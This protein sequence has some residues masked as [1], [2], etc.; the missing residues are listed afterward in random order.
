MKRMTVLGGT[1]FLGS[2]T[3][4][5]L[6]ALPGVEVRTASRR[7]QLSVDVTR[8]HTFGALEGT[9]LLIDLSNA[10]AQAPDELI[11]WC[12]ARGVAVLEATSDASCIERLHRRF[13]GTSGRLVLGGGIFTGMSNLLARDVASRVS[14]LRAVTLGIASSPFSGAGAGTIDL[15]LS[16]LGA[17]VPRYSDHRRIEDAPM[18]KGPILEFARARRPSGRMPLAETFMLHESTGAPDVKVLFAPKPAVLLSAFGLVPAAV[19]RSV[20]GRAA[21]RAYFTVLRRV[22]LR[23]RPGH[24]ELLAAARGATSTASRQ[25]DA[26]DGMWAGAW[27]LAALAEAATATATTG[28]GTGTGTKGGV[29]FI[30]DVASL[31]PIVARANALAGARVLELTAVGGELGEAK[32]V[33]R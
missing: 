4:V 22:F 14:G 21:L 15:M 1:G 30:D 28:P 7:G 33:V 27:A 18:S 6:E 23:S 20:L 17:K 29:Q 5:A 25:L 2:K 26:P 11:G 24:V 9:D 13:A 10:T 3:A 16:V 32:V 19:L 8:P 31:E 12:L